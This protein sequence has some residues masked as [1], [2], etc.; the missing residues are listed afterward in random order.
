MSTDDR[1]VDSV[2]FPGFVE[3]HAHTMGGA[4]WK[5]T[6]VGYHGR[7]SPDGR[8]WDGC[9]SVDEV[10]ARLREA[11]VQVADPEEPLLAW[12]SIRST[13]PVT[14]STAG[15]STRSPVSA[16]YWWCTRAFT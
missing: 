9:R 11:E 3:A 14:G 4:L 5:H 12:V 6:Y 10:V 16:R 7:L 13:S 1:Y 8:H 2:L 15:T